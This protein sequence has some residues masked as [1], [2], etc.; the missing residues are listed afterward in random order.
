MICTAENGNT[1]HGASGEICWEDGKVSV[2]YGKSIP[3]YEI[4]DPLNN[5]CPAASLEA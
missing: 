3:F 5:E 2:F 1:H 4:P